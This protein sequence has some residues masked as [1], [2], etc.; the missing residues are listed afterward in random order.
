MKKICLI[1]N[2]AS[3]YRTAIFMLLDKELDIDFYFGDSMGD[4]KKMDY[5]LLS[6]FKY[7]LKNKIIFSPFYWQKG[8]F[9][10]FFKNYNSYIVTGE[11]FCFST[12]ILLLLS[13]F[14]NKKVYLWTHGWYG[15]EGFL[16]KIIKKTFFNLSDGILL[17]GNYAKKI[18][19]NEG[20]SNEKLHVINNS[21]DYDLQIKVRENL[22]KSNVYQNY[23]KNDNSVL[24]FTGRLNKD[25][26][27]EQLINAIQVLK[28][29]RIFVNLVFVGKGSVQESLKTKMD[30][31]G[32]KDYWFYG[33]CYDENKLG[34]LIYNAAICV[35]PGNIGL[36]AIH[37]LVYGTP[38]IT[39]SNF[40]KQGPEFEA[41]EIGVTGDFFNK[42]DEVDLANKIQKW[43]L[44]SLN[45]QEI[46][47]DC[48]KIIDEK[49]NP[50]FQLKVIK[51]LLDA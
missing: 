12:W 5:S 38:V 20:F 40:S 33:A 14:S 25:K 16:K 48:F 9:S 15:N 37:S 4:I 50:N 24:I 2:F 34:E 1:N 21:L 32:Y 45:R 39:H 13:K 35:S 18:M 44:V 31:L 17:Y 19:I 6:K 28:E 3:H 29:R 49:Y 51:F 26:K 47:K 11:Y 7:E 42:D 36:T 27:L 22:V 43:L 10:L 41:I 46:R 30:F 8:V 23:F